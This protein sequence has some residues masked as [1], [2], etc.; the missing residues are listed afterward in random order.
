V[1]SI[2]KLLLLS[3]G[4]VLHVLLDIGVEHAH[5]VGGQERATKVTLLDQSIVNVE[6]DDRSGSDILEQGIDLSECEGGVG[7]NVLASTDVLREGLL[8]VLFKGMGFSLISKAEVDGTVLNLLDRLVVVHRSTCDNR[9]TRAK[10]IATLGEGNLTLCLCR[11]RHRKRA[12]KS[13]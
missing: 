8:M 2:H 7:R 4:L 13:Y 12:L 5:A 9:T 1:K 11:G 3:E 6:G 10:K